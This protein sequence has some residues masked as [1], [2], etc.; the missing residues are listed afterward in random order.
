MATMVQLTCQH[1]GSPFQREIGQVNQAKKQNRPGPYCSRACRNRAFFTGRKISEATRQK[2]QARIPWNKG[3]P[4]SPAMKQKLSRLASNGN[5]R[6]EKNGHWH[7]G[8]Y[9]NPDGYVEIRVNGKRKLEH[10]H[11]MEQVLGRPL[12][13]N[14][15]VHHRNDDKTDNRP[16]NLELMTSSQHMKHH[17]PNGPRRTSHH[18]PCRICGSIVETT[19]TGD[20]TR[21]VCSSLTCKSVQARAYLKAYRAR[22]RAK[23]AAK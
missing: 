16:G 4:W 19:F 20:L 12:K 7:G 22:K 15:L 10:R 8:R 23:R 14:E 17:N 11:V 5:R 1:C 21:I 3:K 2:Y 18:V 13:R 9:V 6:E